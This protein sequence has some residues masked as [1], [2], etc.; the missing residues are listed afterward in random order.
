MRKLKRLFRTIF[1]MIFIVAMLKA[2]NNFNFNKDPLP[3]SAMSIYIKASDEVSENKLQV[4]WRYVAALDSL[5]IN[6]DFSKANIE[7]AKKI[8]DEFLEINTSENKFKNSNYKLLTFDEVINKFSYTD[9]EKQKVYKFLESINDKYL[10]EADESK[11]EFIDELTPAA[12][13]IYENYGI[14]PSVAIGQAIVESSWGSSTLSAE[15]NNLFGIKSTKS[16]KGKTIDMKTSENYDDTIVATFRA[17]DSKKDSLADYAQFLKNNQRY[18]ENG[19]FDAVDYINQAKAIGIAGYS[20]KK[21]ESGKNIYA[22]LVIQI[23]KEYNLQL[24]DSKV[25]QESF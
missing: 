19:V 23:I 1:F 8:A 25:Q 10:V 24:I 12:I 2:V 4:N 13:S 16:W 21:D 5:R 22:E 15:H 14:L 11:K 6:N 9:K 17:Y 3:K 20:T 18:K 7:D